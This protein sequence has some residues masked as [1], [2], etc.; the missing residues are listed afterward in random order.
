M[1]HKREITLRC[2]SNAWW[3]RTD[4][5]PLGSR[6]L[7]FFLTSSALDRSLSA[8]EIDRGGG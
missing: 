8:M 1:A 2:I 3:G 7:Q 5:M 6:V 4:C